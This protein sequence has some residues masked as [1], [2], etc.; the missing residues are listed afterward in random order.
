MA[1]ALSEINFRKSFLKAG[2]SVNELKFKTPWYPFVPWA[3]FIMSLLSCV[4]II[5]D[6]NQRSALFY[7]IPF[8][9][10]CYAVYYGK[11]Y[12]KKRN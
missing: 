10:L 8:I 11:E 2:H 7:M 1:I 3:A 9:I 5:F 6:P 12:L 4:L